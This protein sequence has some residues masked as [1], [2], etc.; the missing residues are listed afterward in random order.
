MDTLHSAKVSHLLQD[1]HRKSIEDFQNRKLLEKQ[2]GMEQS[3]KTAYMSVTKEEGAYLNAVAK[4][5]NAKHIVEFGCSF[6]IST[7]YLAAAAKDN[8]G[9]VISSEFEPHKVIQAKANLY[10]AGLDAYTTILEGNALGTLLSVTAGID[11]LFLDGAKD[12]YLPIFKRLSPKLSEKAVV[13]ADN[14]DKAA[15]Q[16]YVKY[17]LSQ[18]SFTSNFLFEGRMLIS[19]LN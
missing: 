3:K 7:I 12:L 16:D 10:S 8:G 15:C 6:G 17:M 11:L 1:L 14:A 5:I 13:I 9:A 4:E 18:S 19:I 2:T